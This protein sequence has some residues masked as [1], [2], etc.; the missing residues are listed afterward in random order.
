MI[1]GTGRRNLWCRGWLH[2]TQEEL[3]KWSPGAEGQS[4]AKAT[5]P[6]TIHSRTPGMFGS[7][8]RDQH[9]NLENKRFPLGAVE[10]VSPWQ[11]MEISF[12]KTGNEGK[13]KEGNGKATQGHTE[14]RSIIPRYSKL[15][16][17]L[18]YDKRF[19]GQIS[20]CVSRGAVQSHLATKALFLT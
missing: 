6:P 10:P 2:D 11:S 7:V 8:P 14:G 18:V 17:F 9:T 20:I 5:M 1:I 15:W 13:V 16:A 3:R 19:L 12:L 4:A